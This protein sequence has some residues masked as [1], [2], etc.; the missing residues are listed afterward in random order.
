MWACV[1]SERACVRGER[2]CACLCDELFFG[3]A[4]SQ[5]L[6]AKAKYLAE[7]ELQD[8]RILSLVVSVFGGEEKIS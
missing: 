4:C 6:E 3:D 1:A 5:C 2:V 8:P 7:E